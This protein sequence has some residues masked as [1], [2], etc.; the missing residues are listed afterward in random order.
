[1]SVL[2][3]RLTS[4]CSS[5]HFV[6]SPPGVFPNSVIQDWTEEPAAVLITLSYE[7][8]KELALKS[9]HPHFGQER[10]SVLIALKR[11]RSS[12]SWHTKTAAICGMELPLQNKEPRGRL[13]YCHLL[14]SLAD[15]IVCCSLVE[16]QNIGFGF[17]GRFL[18]QDIGGS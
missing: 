5:L 2:P 1:M 4:H 3:I 17:V 7:W 12:K 9:T 6:M 18:I 13:W 16:K 14:A 15:C 8:M 11:W 10:S